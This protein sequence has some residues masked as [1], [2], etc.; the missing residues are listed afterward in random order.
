MLMKLN[1]VHDY[2]EI[3]VHGEKI[4]TS[5]QAVRSDRSF[6]PQQIYAKNVL[7]SG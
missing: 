1:R 7:I 6:K 3:G 5:L 4:V 2:A